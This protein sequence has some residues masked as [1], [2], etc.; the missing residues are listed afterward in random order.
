VFGL[1]IGSFLNV[2]IHRLPIILERKWQQEE[3][4][5]ESSHESKHAYNIATPPSHCPQCKKPI[6]AWQNIPILSYLLLKGR[7]SHC[8]SP[9]SAAY[10]LVELSAAVLSVVT[11]YRFGPSWEF[12]FASTITYALLCLTLIDIKHRLLPDVITLPL[13]WIG[14][15]LSSQH[16]FTGP[17]EAII[18]A[19][20]GYLSL[21]LVFHGFR[22]ATGKEGLGYGDFKLMAVFGA[23]LGWSYIPVIILIS[24]FLGAIFGG[25]TI[26]VLR[27]GKNFPIPFGPFIALS[28]WSCLLWGEQILSVYLNLINIL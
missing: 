12:I 16:I 19:S 7:C 14:L 28:G 2:V 13:L 22:L 18:G 1:L 24:S 9:I 23:W 11:A 8:Q 17:S 3:N 4:S 5:F 10:P 6:R 15:L 25:I 21:W 26:L 27:V 20:I